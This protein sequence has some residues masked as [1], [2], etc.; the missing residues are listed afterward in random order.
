V[1]LGITWGFE[2]RTLKDKVYFKIN[3]TCQEM[4]KRA[5]FLKLISGQE[6]LLQLVCWLT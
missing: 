4:F 5:G 6:M 2:G 1:C 3:G